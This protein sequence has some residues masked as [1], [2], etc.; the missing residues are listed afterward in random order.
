MLVETEKDDKNKFFDLYVSSEPSIE[1]GFKSFDY[2]KFSAM[3]V[4]FSSKR[5]ELLK[6]K[7]MKLLNY[8]DMIFYKENSISIS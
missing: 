4:F 1:N 7:L 5:K 3:V 6:T 2:E 8:A